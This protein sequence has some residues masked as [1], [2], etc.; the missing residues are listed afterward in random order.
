MSWLGVEY[1]AGVHDLFMTA[2]YGR[3]S[4]FSEIAP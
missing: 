1:V 3:D 4:P 2:V